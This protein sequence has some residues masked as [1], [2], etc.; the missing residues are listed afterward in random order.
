M[1]TWSSLGRGGGQARKQKQQETPPRVSLGEVEH[2]TRFNR[3]GGAFSKLGTL[4]VQPAIGLPLRKKRARSRNDE[5]RRRNL[6]V[7][8]L[9]RCTAARSEQIDCGVHD[10]TDSGLCIKE[11]PR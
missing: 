9:F 2:Q 5:A 10:V 8:P 1:S 4:D 3:Q 11:A 6:E 7:V